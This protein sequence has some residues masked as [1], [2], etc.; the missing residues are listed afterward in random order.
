LEQK[1]LLFCLMEA[2]QPACNA[3][4]TPTPKHKLRLRLLEEEE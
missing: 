1:F 4:Q 2:T 3:S